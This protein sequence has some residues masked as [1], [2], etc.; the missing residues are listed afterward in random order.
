M[1]HFDQQIR[2]AEADAMLGKD[3]AKARDILPPF[4]GWPGHQV[5]HNI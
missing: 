5:T 1:E 2:T 3:L 4:P